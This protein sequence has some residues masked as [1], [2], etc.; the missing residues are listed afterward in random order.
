MP[1]SVQI[2]VPRCF[3][4]FLT[5]SMLLGL[6]HDELAAHLK[7]LNRRCHQERSAVAS[8]ASMAATKSCLLACQ[9]S[10]L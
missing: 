8:S 10:S 6:Q 1:E 4:E 2:T 3:C 5:M 9:A 7:Q